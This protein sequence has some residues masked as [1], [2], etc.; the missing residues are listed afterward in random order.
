[1]SAFRPADVPL[2]REVSRALAGGRS[3]AARGLLVARYGR[4]VG[5]LAY[6]ALVETMPGPRGPGG[7]GRQ[8]RRR[9]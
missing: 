6:Q 3:A 7:R 5:L 8:K 1:M 9:R 4:E 2:M